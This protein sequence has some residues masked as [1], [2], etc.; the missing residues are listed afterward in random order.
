MKILAYLELGQQFFRIAPKWLHFFRRNRVLSFSLRL[1]AKLIDV[2][3]ACRYFIILTASI[4]KNSTFELL[5]N[6]TYIFGLPQTSVR[7]SSNCMNATRWTQTSNWMR[8]LFIHSSEVL[9]TRRKD[10]KINILNLPKTSLHRPNGSEYKP[11][12]RYWSEACC[13]QPLLV[14]VSV[15][16]WVKWG[17][18]CARYSPTYVKSHLLVDMTNGSLVP[19]W[20]WVWIRIGSQK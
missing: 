19:N 18:R 7:V 14:M 12:F 9:S 2:K 10:S 13:L 1:N 11:G 16:L 6:E 15:Q 8:D 4:T 17:N 20:Q 3:E 5:I